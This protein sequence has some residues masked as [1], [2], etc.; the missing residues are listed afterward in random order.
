MDVLNIKTEIIEE[1]I[2]ETTEEIKPLPVSPVDMEMKEPVEEIKESVISKP[3][4][5]VIVETPTG[6]LDRHGNPK[7][8]VHARGRFK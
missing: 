5:E 8:K 3:K 6:P 7:K 4:E 2:E 1:K